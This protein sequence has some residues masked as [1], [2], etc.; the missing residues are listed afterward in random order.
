MTHPIALPWRPTQAWGWLTAHDRGLLA[1]RRAARTAIVMPLMFALGDKVIKNPDVA[2]FAAFGSFALLMLVDFGGPLRDR[3]RAQAALSLVGAAFVCI[4]TLASREAWLAAVAMAVI[5]FGVLFAGVVSSVLAGAT[6]S[7]LLSFILPVSLSAK[8]SVILDRLAG[9]GMAA[10]AALIAVAVLW[11][12]PA[13]DPLRA[14]AAAACRALAARLRSEVAYV[15]AAKRGKEYE[16]HNEAILAADQAVNELRRIFLATPYRPTGLS[17]SARAVIRLIDEL[18]WLNVILIEVRKPTRNRPANK[19][20]CAVKKAAATVLEHG[21]HLLEHP[22]ASSE[23]LETALEQLH[24]ALIA[25]E[26]SAADELPDPDATGADEHMPEEHVSEV[27]DALDPSFRAQELSFMVS[28]IGRNIDEAAQAE[29]RSWIDRLAGRRPAADVVG[30]GDGAPGRGLPGRRLPGTLSAAQERA[31]AH[32]EPHSVWLHNSLR[33]AIGLG[34]AV[35]VADLT[36]VQ[37]SFWVVLGTLSVLRTSALNTG[38]NAL[39]AVLGTSAGVVI[40]GLLLVPIGSDT[41]LLWFLLPVAILVAGVAPA[42]ISFAAGQTGFTVVLVILYNII[43]PVG[44]KVGLLRIEDIAIGCAV[45]LVV[46][47]LFWPRGA[48]AALRKAMA[49][50]YADSARYLASAVEFGVLRCDAS[51]QKVLGVLGLDGVV[52]EPAVAEAAIA[53]G[54]G[55]TNGATAANGANGMGAGM[56]AG[57]GSPSRSGPQSRPGPRLSPPTQQAIRAAAAARRMD[58]TFRSYLAERGAKAMPLADVTRLVTGVAGLRLAADAVLDLWDRDDGS[59]ADDRAPARIELLRHLETIRNWYDDLAGSLEGHGDVPD[60]LDRDEDSASRLIQAVRRD[61]RDE[62]G[63]ATSTA[64]RMI[65]T[66]DHL[67][68]VRRLQQALVKPATAAADRAAGRSPHG[69]PDR[70]V[71]ATAATA[72]S[73]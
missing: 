10:G 6:T 22:R 54:A 63:Q 9:W 29:R 24:A 69:E 12:A 38:Q 15:L 53:N 28:L 37:H 68:A 8:P 43:Q 47:L 34:L 46:G 20:V 71:S 25:L 27:V 17:T 57:A 49:E 14:K 7:L 45:S 44:W 72:A 67:D 13:Q 18:S 33:G 11:P 2:T 4:G 52:V 61:L 5:G 73:S 39:R 3:L 64:V 40:G 50:A 65:W 31:A 41:D 23:P 1:L 26:Q 66:G 70:R 56:G 30:A 19:P 51:A 48:A 36:A 35:L 60:A 42:A 59:A 62:D 58:D 32:I 16:D 55:V 21:A